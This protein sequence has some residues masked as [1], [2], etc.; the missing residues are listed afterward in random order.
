M[1]TSSSAIANSAALLA[2]FEKFV[3]NSAPLRN[4]EMLC[5]AGALILNWQFGICQWFFGAGGRDGR[6]FGAL[7]PS[8]NPL[9]VGQ[10]LTRGRKAAVTST[11]IARV[12][13]QEIYPAPQVFLSCCIE[14][15]IRKWNF[16]G[17]I[18]ISRP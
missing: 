14:I 3:C 5:F 1:A 6:R 16:P 15:E 8:P 18:L 17:S 7:R 2:T 13:R 4:L 12:S 10:E 9:P 11:M